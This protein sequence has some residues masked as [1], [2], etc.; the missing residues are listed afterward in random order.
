MK[1]ADKVLRHAK[2]PVGM[3]GKAVIGRMNKSHAQLTDWGLHQITFHAA[4][5]VL[6][7]GCGGGKALKKMSMAAEQASLYGIDYS[8]TSVSCAVKENAAD[9]KTG[10]MHIVQGTVSELPYQDCFFDVITSIESYYFWPQL[11]H[12]FKEVYRVLKE[13]GTFAIIAEMYVHEGQRQRDIE[14]VELL[15]MHN[16]TKEQLRQLFCD[17]GYREVVVNTQEDWIFVSGK[18]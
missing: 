17:A 15:A 3:M 18:K 14:I 4:D 5:T 2:K 8:K 11:A 1:I 9:V 13:G 6:D 7:I 12:D 10:K 16:H